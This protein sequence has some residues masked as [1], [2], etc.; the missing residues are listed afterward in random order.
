MGKNRGKFSISIQKIFR[1]GK[2]EELDI[3]RELITGIDS[4]FDCG[5]QIREMFG[6]NCNGC[7]GWC[8]RCGEF[9]CIP[10]QNILEALPKE[11]GE[12]RFI[13]LIGHRCRC[14]LYIEKY[15]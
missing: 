3:P 15:V 7:N 1:D 12:V 8:N 9:G 10:T 4:P 2:M 6:G 14:K 5:K 11:R 13:T